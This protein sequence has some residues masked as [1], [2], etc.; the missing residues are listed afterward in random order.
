[1]K[2]LKKWSFLL[3]AVLLAMIISCK[4][5][6]NG[7]IVGTDKKPLTINILSNDDISFS[8]SNASRTIMA[9][10]FTTADTLYFYLWGSAP[11]T[12]LAPKKLTVTPDASDTA[13]GTVVLDID[14]YNWELTIAAC[15]TDNLTTEADILADAVL[16]GYGNVDMMFTNNINFTL[17]P[18]GL[19]KPGFV[20]VTIA[21][22]SGTVIPA[23]Y[24]VKANIYNKKTG[25]PVLTTSGGTLEQTLMTATT[26]TT[27]ST[28]FGTKTYTVTGNNKIAPGT[29]LFQVEF[30][31]QDELR[32]FVWHDNIII[33]PGRTAED[34]IVIP[35]KI[36]TKPN[37]PTALTVT[38]NADEEEEAVRGKYPVTITWNQD[39]VDNELYF[40]LQIA[41]LNDDLPDGVTLAAVNTATSFDT[42]WNT[43]A[44]YKD[45]WEFNYLNDIRK[46]LRFY[47]EGS[48][49]SNNT[50]IQIYLE[51]GKRYIL[52]MYS[53]NNAGYSNPAYVTTITPP[54]TGAT[55][56]NT[57][58]RFKVTYNNQGGTWKNTTTNATSTAKKI[59]YWSQSDAPY[60]LINPAAASPAFTL[61]KSPATFIYWKKSMAGD[62]WPTY[63]QQTGTFT[64]ENYDGFKN[65]N[66]YAGYSR[67]AGF[68]IL[69]YSDYDIV[70]EYVSGFGAAA[71]V[72]DKEA[73]YTFNVGSATTTTVSL[74]LPVGT[75]ENP[76]TWTYDNVSLQITYSGV[77][78]YDEEATGAPRG[79]G[80]TFNINLATLPHGYRYDCF[81]E[82]Q[83][84]MINVSYP[85]TIDLRD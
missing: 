49:F 35:N 44:N 11:G 80:N 30:E 32:K 21:L 5:S 34:P 42:I 26:T 6:A 58:N 36:G 61:T 33:L 23:G 65:V 76:P 50:E 28:T 60:V 14:C 73:T 20:N 56:L 19:T 45:K 46:D 71:G 52:R 82:A 69:D 78:F 38:F 3:L 24:G 75:G 84:N 77:I 40:A 68:E 62:F 4:H 9:E 85:F 17:S 8:K 2:N 29:Y 47:K 25:E 51:L 37:A 81:L 48:L 79:A 27:D 1:M 83:Y 63:N 12:T 10:S 53:E 7:T 74:T 66:L 59:E 54:D 15:Q 70:P 64:P 41:E 57:I 39:T 18:K 43:A 55:T 22:E 13:K 72:I 67:E 16:I 31:K